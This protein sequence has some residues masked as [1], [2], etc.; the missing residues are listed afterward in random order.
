MEQKQNEEIKKSKSKTK[1]SKENKYKIKLK[2]EVICQFS[3]KVELYLKDENQ[4]VLKH[5]QNTIEF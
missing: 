2:K 1:I 4:C 3:A 5:F